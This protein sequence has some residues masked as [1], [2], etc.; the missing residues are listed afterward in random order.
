MSYGVSDMSD[1]ELKKMIGERERERERSFV[2]E[3]MELCFYL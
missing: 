3:Y 1:S 2:D